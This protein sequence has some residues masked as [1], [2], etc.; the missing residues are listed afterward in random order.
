MAG[1]R[2]SEGRICDE[3]V[4]QFCDFGVDGVSLIGAVRSGLRLDGF[5]FR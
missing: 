4:D 1:A 2:S 3:F 5:M